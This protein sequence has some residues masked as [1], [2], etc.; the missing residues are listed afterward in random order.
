MV[1]RDVGVREGLQ[2]L[3]TTHHSLVTCYALLAAH[4]LLT[5]NLQ[6]RDL[7]LQR[8]RGVHGTLRRR[9]DAAVGDLLDGHQ[10]A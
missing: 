3:L 7:A 9:R 6:A 8:L 1:D 5:T 2:R 10:L 4:C